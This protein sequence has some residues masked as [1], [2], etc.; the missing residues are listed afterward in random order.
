[1]GDGETTPPHGDALNDDAAAQPLMQ[2][3]GATP[4]HGDG[5]NE[6]EEHGPDVPDR[7]ART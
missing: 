1:M 4:S 6:A 7:D 5:I 3:D 2:D